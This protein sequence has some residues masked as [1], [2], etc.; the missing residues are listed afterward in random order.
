M[1]D[2]SRLMNDSNRE[3][4]NKAKEMAEGKNQAQM[5]DLYKQ[6]AQQ[7]GIPLEQ[8]KQLASQFNIRF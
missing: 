2:M 8:L 5:I 3:L 7:K 6:I 1:F 4:F